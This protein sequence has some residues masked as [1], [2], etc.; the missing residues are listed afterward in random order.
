MK[1]KDNRT[2]KKACYKTIFNHKENKDFYIFK[3]K[4]YTSK[5]FSYSD[6]YNGDLYKGDVC[7]IFITYGT[8]NH[9]Y[10]IEVAPNGSIFL[11]DILNINDNFKN[12][13][14]DECFIKATAQIK[15][16]HYKVTISIPKSY[17]KGSV[18]EYNAY[19]IETDGG[20][21]DKHLFALKPTL[22]NTFHKRKSF[23]KLK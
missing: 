6:K 20:E 1:L 21:M 5:F 11:S 12:I 15:R 22:C 4:A 14:L 3:F 16:N 9:Y 8:K 10:E 23:V 13:M 18:I 17:I 2:G 19:R 7:E